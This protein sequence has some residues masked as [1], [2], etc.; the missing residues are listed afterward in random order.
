[1]KN[2]IRL[3]LNTGQI[4]TG[5]S[6]GADIPQG[7]EIISELVFQ[8]GM[9]GYPESLT[10]PS[11]L[12]QILVL[13]YPLIGNYGIAEPQYDDNGIDKIFESNDIHIKALIV[14]EYNPKYSHWRG[15][16]SLGEWLASRGIVAISGVDTRELTKIIRDNRDVIARIT[17]DQKPTEIAT[18]ISE[19]ANNINIED[20]SLKVS[21]FGNVLAP[22][23]DKIVLNKG[24]SENILVIDCGIKN[25]QLRALLKRNV[26]ITVINTQYHFLEEVRRGEYSGI[27]ISNGPGNPER[28]TNIISQ[29]SVILNE[30]LN[31]PI[32]G[33]C[34]G[35]QILSLSAGAHV[36]RMKYGN[37]GHNIP[38]NLIGTKK[39]Y[40]TSQ[41]H[42]YEV[43]TSDLRENSNWTDLFVN[44]NDNTNEGIINTEQPYFSVQFHPEARAGPQDT[45]FLFNIFVE[46]CKQPDRFNVYER[47]YETI[48]P[49][50]GPTSRVTVMHKG[51]NKVLIL[52]SGGLS[53]GQAGE[54]D[55]S[56]SQAIKAYK[57]EGI[58]VVLINPNIATIQTSKGLAD[59]IYY[60]PITKEYVKQVIDKEKPDGI[61]LSFGG[62]TAL[63]CGIQLHAAGYLEGVEIL[64]SSLQTVMDAED[65]KRFK[66]ILEEIGEYTAPSEI[67]TTIEEATEIS[68]EIGFP[69][70][71]RSSFALGGLGSGFANNLE[72]MTNILKIG[73]REPDS[74]VIIDKSLRGWKELEYEIVR[75]EYDN[76]ISVCNMENVDPLGIHTGESIVVAPSQTLTDKEYNCLRTVAFKVVRRLGIVGECNIQYALDPESSRYYIIEVNPRLSRSSAL[77]S[78]ATGYPLA[79]I[80]AKLSLGYSLLDIKNSITRLTA[81][82]EPSLDYCIIK[83]P[84]WDLRKFPMVNDK[85]GSSM[86]S[87]GEVMSISRSFEEAFQKALRMAD[88]NIVGFYG[89]NSNAIVT[90]DEL[91]NPTNDRMSKIANAFY[92]GLYDVDK[93][94]ELTRIDKWYLKKLWKIIEMQIYLESV[95]GNVDMETLYRAKRIG[96]SDY[97]L[98]R[99]LKKTEIYVR[100]LREKNNIKPVVKQLDTVAAEYPCYT[101]YLYLTYNGDYHDIEF[102]DKTVTVLGSGVYRIGSSVE[103]DWCAVNCVRELRSLG[104]KTVMI[105]YNPETVSTD[106]DEVDRLYFDEITFETV[107]DIY[108]LENSLGVVL[109]MGGQVANNIAMSLY[110]KGVKVLG[111]NP[112]NIDSA[113][114]RFKFSRML[115]TIGID[116]PKWKEL[117]DNKSTKDFCDE[118]GFPCLVRPSYVLS[119]AM[120]SVIYSE[121]ELDHFLDNVEISSDYPVV[122]SKFITNAKEIEIDAVADNGILK[123]FAISEHV[124]DAGVHSGDATLIL[125]PKNINEITANRL[126]VNTEKIAKQLEINGPFNIQYIAKNNELKVIECNLRVSRS[127]PFVSKVRDINFI[128]IATKIMMGEEYIIPN[129]HPKYVGVKVSQFS[130][131]RLAN[132][133]TRLGVEMLST[134]EVACFGNNYQEAYLKALVATGFKICDIKENNNVLMSVGSYPNKQELEDTTNKLLANG[135]NIYASYGTADYYNQKLEINSIIG[136]DTDQILDYIQQDK[137]GLVI[138]ISIPNKVRISKKKTQGYYIRRYAIDYGVSVITNIKCVKLYVDSIIAR[139]HQSTL[140]G[141]ADLKTSYNRIK[142]PACIDMHVHVREPGDEHKET[143]ETCTQSALAG[144]IGMI[145]A[146]PNTKPPCT[147]MDNWELTNKRASTTK[148]KCDYML[149]MGADGK[150]WDQMAEMKDKVCGIKFYLNETYSELTISDI[151]VLRKYF[152]HCPDDMLMCFHAES[153]QLGTVLYLA[154]IYKRRVHICHISLKAEIEMIKDAKEAGLSVTCEVTPHHLFLTAAKNKDLLLTVKPNM[155]SQEDKDALWENMDIIDCIATDHAPHLLSEKQNTGCPGF[156]GL[157]TALPLLLNAVSEGRLTIG[158]IVAKYHT[159]PKRILRLPNDYLSDSYV[160][161]NLDKKYTIH[162]DDIVSRAGWT[163]FDGMKV[164]GSIENMCIAPRKMGGSGDD[165]NKSEYATNMTSKRISI[166]NTTTIE[167]GMRLQDLSQDSESSIEPE[168]D[169][170]ELNNSGSEH[171]GDPLG[172]LELSNVVDVNGF[173]RNDLRILFREANEIKQYIKKYGN[174]NTL[175]GKIV[176]LYFEE[177]STRTYSSF[178]SAIQK[179]GGNVL[180]IDG[181]TS[182]SKKGESLLD[183][184]KCL[185]IYCDLLIIRS[186]STGLN[187]IVNQLSIPVINAG[188]GIGEHPTQ[189]LLDVFTIR[190]E[191][192]TVNNIV[193]SVVGDLKRGRTVHSLIKL[194]HNYEGISFNFVAQTGMELEN[195]FLKQELDSRCISYN[196]CNNGLDEVI[197]T[198][199]VLYMTRIQHEKQLNTNMTTEPSSPTQHKLSQE[200]LTNAK[201][202]MVIMHPLPRNDEIPH[203]IDADPRVAYF[204]QMENGLYIRMALLKIILEKN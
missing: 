180:P 134:G 5:K 150:N 8:T 50:D 186:K 72:E 118:V 98:S 166:D 26:T 46:C 146:M 93:M 15:K 36:K 177:P 77:A 167:L 38:C 103:F 11:Y 183:T 51:I 70:L 92:S 175:K 7:D 122:I 28:C 33:I 114:N 190:E 24:Q 199:D 161:I 39:C 158:D 147:N 74:H 157:E 71:I 64:G 193:V 68:K 162:N 141:D 145:C 80:A 105:N 35:H 188:D 135:Y 41:N 1:M 200:L 129:T 27:F 87:V 155:N 136:L 159:N 83:V 34:L 179:L 47:V 137:F 100:D 52:G 13:T 42:G 160:E 44:C 108:G 109:C 133:D 196:V 65:R 57:E 32:F 19:I 106:Y 142:I 174:M 21:P 140:I 25:S 153:N 115:D 43:I 4:F 75:D 204:R 203:D 20:V 139:Y 185:E 151:S 82:Y 127:F 69:L 154:S 88:E 120:M 16:Q 63:N 117:V 40:I 81:C 187:N 164:H 172:T 78:K 149:F 101:N 22:N 184:L 131:N 198:T 12:N 144:G 55:Y 110:R 96:F 29:L 195:E 76:C 143:W 37:R 9:V 124:E 61:S 10:D 107:M 168:L 197:E 67:A 91:I 3:Q 85:L 54:F 62:Q 94:Y 123:I 178:V 104:Y 138:N 116:Q 132:A 6:F 23:T 66:N 31:I 102:D 60:L 192:G 125:P 148:T 112:E 53:I 99:M 56:G 49:K 48:V 163:P 182:S 30:K 14:G 59:K 191:R 95:T 97:Q 18:D 73:L 126:R 111:T 176:G 90:E 45:E 79:Y 86:K 2:N 130:F 58:E 17:S 165:G 89:T 121:E 181:N 194:L 189:A 84:R 156:A 173:T 170:N 202:T 169:L 171:G 152:I 201:P 119:G 128:K 113:E